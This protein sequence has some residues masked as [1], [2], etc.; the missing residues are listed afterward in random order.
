MVI[1]IANRREGE[2]VSP[3]LQAADGRVEH[4]GRDEYQHPV[5]D[6]SRHVHR[7]R[8]GLA[9]EQIDRYVER[10][11]ERRVASQ[12]D[13]IEV[14]VFRTRRE[15][16]R[17][18]ERER[19]EEE[20]EA[21]GRHVVQRG[22]AVELDVGAGEQHLYGHDPHSL[23]RDGPHE[24]HEPGEVEVELAV[25]RYPDAERDDC[26]VH[27]R[28]LFVR[29]HLENAPDGV[30]HARHERLDHLDESDAQVDVRGVPHPQHHREEPRDGHD[31]S[32]VRLPAHVDAFHD[33]EHADEDER[34]RGAEGHVDHGERHREREAEHG[35]DVL[36]VE[37]DS[38]AHADPQPDVG[39]RD[40]R[41]L[42]D[43]RHL[44]PQ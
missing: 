13:G 7:E 40:E 26:H 10:E 37:D 15:P 19:G 8:A 43:T 28:L 2:K 16:R 20:H 22:D 38:R 12:H 14:D 3:Q 39:V 41:L 36:V 4:H 25:G 9:Y 33:A 42:E 29:L 31:L 6:D 18:D 30:H 27:H 34:E 21:R 35:Q 17:L 32:D 24:E 11:R 23:A 5:L 1:V 44:A